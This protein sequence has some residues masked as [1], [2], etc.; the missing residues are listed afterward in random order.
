MSTAAVRYAFIFNFE[1]HNRENILPIIYSTTQKI[2]NIQEYS[3]A[4]SEGKF[5]KIPF[6]FNTLSNQQQQTGSLITK[7]CMIIGKL[8]VV[9]TEGDQSDSFIFYKKYFDVVNDILVNFSF[10]FADHPILSNNNNVVDNNSKK[11]K[12]RDDSSS[13]INGKAIKKIDLSSSSS[14]VVHQIMV[15]EPVK[16]AE[17]KLTLYIPTNAIKASSLSDRVPIYN[18]SYIECFVNLNTLIK[19][20]LPQITEKK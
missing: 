20:Y 17:Q 19:T 2:N 14:N 18:I 12:D 3:K 4:D 5:I 9:T 15:N 8:V 16:I 7:Q 10:V 6:Y 11:R 13:V 1:I